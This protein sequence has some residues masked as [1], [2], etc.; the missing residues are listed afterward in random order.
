MA[1]HA[2]GQVA[3]LCQLENDVRKSRRKRV[4]R[5]ERTVESVARKRVKSEGKTQSSSDGAVGKREEQRKRNQQRHT[6][7]RMRGREKKREERGKEELR[8][9]QIF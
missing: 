5:R 2:V 3:V 9:M 7:R 1:L 4:S 8:E 6:G